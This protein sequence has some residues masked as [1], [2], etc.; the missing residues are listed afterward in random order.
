MSTREVIALFTQ[1]IEEQRK[2]PDG[3]LNVIPVLLYDYE[4]DQPLLAELARHLG[5]VAISADEGDEPAIEG[6]PLG[7]PDGS[8]VLASFKRLLDEVRHP[9]GAKLVVA[10]VNSDD[11]YAVR[12]E[13]EPAPVNPGDRNFLGACTSLLHG[14]LAGQS[15]AL[16]FYDGS[17]VDVE[18]RA[19]LWR[20]FTEQLA[21]AGVPGPTTLIVCVGGKEIDICYL[22]RGSSLR[23]AVQQDALVRRHMW[24]TSEQQAARLAEGSKPLV[25]F[26]GAGASRA[27]NLPLGDHLRDEALRQ[28]LRDASGATASELKRMFF[29]W[30]RD[31]DRLRRDEAD[32]NE[33][34]FVSTLTLERVLRE[35]Y[36]ESP[37]QG[38][39]PVLAEFAE[40]EAAALRNPPP[41]ILALREFLLKRKKV[42]VVT[43]NFDRLVEHGLGDQAEVFSTDEGFDASLPLLKDKLTTG[44]GKIPVLKLHGSIEKPA[45][46][47]AN[48]ELTSLGLSPQRSAALNA[49]VGPPNS[50][51]D[52]VYVGYSMRDQ[53]ILPEISIPRVALGIDERWVAP[54]PDAHVEHLV[55]SQRVPVWQGNKRISTLHERTITETAETFFQ[56]LRERADS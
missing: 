13:G 54:T 38:L 9:K 12:F 42:V 28:F 16:V 40:S 15:L 8:G 31:N 2:R 34:T 1:I 46:I 20:M 4:N 55:S 50:P 19:V 44:L 30:V 14:G 33:R 37:G 3:P 47:V 43:V 27:A 23:Y 21:D 53:D 25:L 39:P 22:G 5:A 56:L 32:G 35:V 52:W 26:L 24:G 10:K 41:G 29:D 45:S 17:A 7:G 6:V 18:A 48:V 49:L 51:I 36:H 11:Y